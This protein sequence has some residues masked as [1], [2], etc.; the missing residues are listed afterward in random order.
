MPAAETSVLT[1]TV[2]T[3]LEKVMPI[4]VEAE[5]TSFRKNPRTS[6]RIR[7]LTNSVTANIGGL[8]ASW[9]TETDC[10]AINIETIDVPYLTFSILLSEFSPLDAAL[11]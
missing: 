11:T 5:P 9:S 7:Q 6:P 3:A 10:A 4:P 1:K 2:M 8:D